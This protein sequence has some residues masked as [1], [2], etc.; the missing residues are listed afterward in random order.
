MTWRPAHDGYQVKSLGAGLEQVSRRLGISSPRTSAAIFGSWAEIAGDQVARHARPQGLRNGVLSV[1]VDDPRWSTQLR[2]LS[3]Q[4]VTKCNAL[5]GQDLV[6][7]VEV[8]IGDISEPPSGWD[9]PE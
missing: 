5:L 6:E 3:P 4:L 2:W 9:S 7:R 8:R 1:V